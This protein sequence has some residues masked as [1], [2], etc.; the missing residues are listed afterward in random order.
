M[1]TFSKP[2]IVID[3][4]SVNKVAGVLAMFNVSSRAPPLMLSNEFKVAPVPKIALN[5]S[6]PAVEVDLVVDSRV[7]E[8]STPV[9]SVKVWP[10]L[11]PPG[12]ARPSY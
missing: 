1:F 11:G 10:E 2:A 6:F 3:A 9:V 12:T 4:G 8:V 5:V 7:P